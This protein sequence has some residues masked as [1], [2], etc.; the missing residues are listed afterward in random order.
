[1]RLLWESCRSGFSV[2]VRLAVYVLLC[3]CWDD[4]MVP[5]KALRSGKVYACVA[6]LDWLPTA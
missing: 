4:A 2:K 1:M 6:I 5:T 3:E